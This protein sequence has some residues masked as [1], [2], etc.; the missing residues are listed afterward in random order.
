MDLTRQERDPRR[1]RTNFVGPL[2]G[3]AIGYGVNQLADASGRA[4]RRR[5]DRAAE[6]ALQ[7]VQNWMNEGPNL[8][9]NDPD[10]TQQYEPG[11][12]EMEEGEIP[13]K[14]NMTIGKRRRGGGQY[15]GSFKRP[16]TGNR[17]G[18]Y[19]KLG[20]KMET[21][22]SGVQN[23][24]RC[25]YLGATSVL[26][27]DIGFDVGV[28]MLR[29]IMNRQYRMKY[30]D[31]N[32]KIWPGTF[33]AAD[34]SATTTVPDGTVAPIQIKFFRSFVK[35]GDEQMTTPRIVID[36]WPNA[37]A[38]S[39]NPARTVAEFAASFR[40]TVF[41]NA[42][43]RNTAANNAESVILYGYSIVENQ[44]ILDSGQIRN[45]PKNL[46]MVRIDEMYVKCYCKLQMKIQNVTAPDDGQLLS[47][48]LDANPIQGKLYHFKDPVPILNNALKDQDGNQIAPADTVKLFAVN[49]SIIKPTVDTFNNPIDG[50]ND[51][52]GYFHRPPP[53]NIFRNCTR[54]SNIAMRPGD[55]KS[56]SISFNFDGRLR[57]LIQKMH[58][59][60]PFNVD[61]T[62]STLGTSFVMGFEKVMNTGA[63][64][65]TVNY[66]ITKY[67][68]A[69][70]KKVV[71][72]PFQVY[73]KI[74]PEL[75]PTVAVA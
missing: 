70:V 50:T 59:G 2:V 26:A 5:V 23:M 60:A 11:D 71:T 42:D 33:Q 74:K 75:A 64:K 25:M 73:N 61:S 32:D 41:L 29:Y 10:A 44:R 56:H 54:Y 31:V 19:Q 1:Q 66:Q 69:M 18:Q 68:G 47:T 22:R 51:L 34:F 20:Y 35:Q 46:P 28:A 55:I 21:E 12:Q 72:K 37:I 67:H 27:S 4:V 38:G 36:L 8:T 7:V 57:D 58:G 43:F 14:T 24:S 40:D 48:R 49:D 52:G 17:V 65:I 63:D 30:V 45:I 62:D 53:A 13:Q 16:K 6:D 9:P 39:Q 15:A 3:G